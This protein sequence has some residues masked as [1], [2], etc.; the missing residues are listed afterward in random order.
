[1]KW[2]ALSGQISNRFYKIRRRRLHACR[3]GCVCTRR[4][5]SSGQRELD[6]RKERLQQKSIERDRILGLY[7]KGRIDEATLDG[8]LDEVEKE[9]GALQ[10]EI[11]QRTRELN[12][13]DRRVQLQSAEVLLATLR[14]QLDEEIS[15]ELKRRI[16]E[17]LVEKIEAN[18]V[19]RWGVRQSELTIVYRFHQPEE[20]APLFLPRCHRIGARNELVKPPSTLGDHLRYRRLMLKLLQR[21][22]AQQLGASKETV[23]S[24]EH[25]R[26]KPA[27]KYMPA[28]VGFLGYR[29]P[30]EMDR[31]V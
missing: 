26:T 31:P 6:E 2:S 30:P 23:Y 5:A 22:V 19:D 13:D 4:T 25:N 11:K 28:I 16:F 29:P 8:Q 14:S 7:R 1:M 27:L 24:W 15:P 20:A 18:V 12:G 17:S 9:W 10:G 3:N 21:Q